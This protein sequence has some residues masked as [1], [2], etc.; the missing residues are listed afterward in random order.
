MHLRALYGVYTC[1]YCNSGAGRWASTRSRAASRSAA[2]LLSRCP[3]ACSPAPP[4]LSVK[5]PRLLLP[6]LGKITATRYTDRLQVRLVSGQ[7][8]ADFAKCADNLA[9]G[10]GAL[11][12]RVRSARSGRVVLEFVRR[13]ALAALTPAVPIPAAP[14]LKALP[15]G[16]REDGLPWLVRL[17]GT[18]VLVGRARARPA[19]G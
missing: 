18:H 10:F 17:H 12:C 8:A 4:P 2:V 19:P 1:M 9:Q 5:T 13:D 14:D 7:S 6:V 11:L 16:R 3:A 15:V